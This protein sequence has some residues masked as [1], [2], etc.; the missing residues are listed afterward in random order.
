MERSRRELCTVNE[1]DSVA[2]V[3][4]RVGICLLGTHL[5]TSGGILMVVTWRGDDTTGTW[6]LEMLLSISQNTGQPQRRTWLKR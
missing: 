4:T 1:Y 2:L 5:A 6:E 3:F